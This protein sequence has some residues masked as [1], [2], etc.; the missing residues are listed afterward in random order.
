[1]GA[2]RG[3]HSVD[4]RLGVLGAGGGAPTRTPPRRRVAVQ[5]E[6]A[7]DEQLGADVARRTVH[8]SDGVVEDAQVP[9][10]GG[11]PLCAGGVSS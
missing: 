7:D 5:R 6:L 1:V 4:E 8:H 10:L 11:E 2:Q 3:D 9:Q